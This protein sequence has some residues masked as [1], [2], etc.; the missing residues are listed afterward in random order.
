MLSAI[1]ANGCTRRFTAIREMWVRGANVSKGYWRNPERTALSFTPDGWFRTGDVVKIDSG[2]VG[3]EP[4]IT[5]GQT[6]LRDGEVVDRWDWLADPGIEIP[7]GASAVHGIT[8]E[9]V[10]GKLTFDQNL[11]QLMQLL[12][13]ATQPG[14]I[15]IDVR[16]A[17]E[18]A[19]DHL[20][21]ATNI[22]VDQFASRSVD[23]P[24]TNLH[25]VKLR[26]TKK[27]LRS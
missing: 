15:V 21:Q 16:T 6:R 17:E 20:P 19:S 24:G 23:Q 11:P 3:G 2:L 5:E 7:E 27:S 25:E 8:D 22:P 18:F 12:H 10:R 26:A 9:M 13:V 14:A 4:V 1:A